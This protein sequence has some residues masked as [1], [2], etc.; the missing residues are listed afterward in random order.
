MVR[1]LI[2]FPPTGFMFDVHLKVSFFLQK[3]RLYCCVENYVFLLVATTVVV[4]KIH[5]TFLKKVYHNIRGCGKSP[6]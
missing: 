3:K 1:Q 5:L 2:A 6:L 4:L